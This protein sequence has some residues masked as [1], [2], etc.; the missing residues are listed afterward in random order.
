MSSAAFL[1]LAK[2]MVLT[3][4]ETRFAKTRAPR[5][6]APPPPL[7]VEQGRVAEDDPPLARGSAVVIHERER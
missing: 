4:C 3:P 5:S 1:V 2:A 6:E 7:L